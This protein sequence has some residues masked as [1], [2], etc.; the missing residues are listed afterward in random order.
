VLLEIHDPAIAKAAGVPC[1]HLSAQGCSVHPNWPKV[2][3]TW[4]CVWRLMPGLPEQWRP[5]LSGILLYQVRNEVPGYHDTAL[6]L[7][8]AHGLKHL[9]NEELL[10]FVTLA[11]RN[12]QPVYLGVHKLKDGKGASAADNKAVFINLSLEPAIARND[13]AGFVEILKRTIE[14]KLAQ[15]GTAA[16]NGS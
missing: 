11:V 9:E 13:R 5:D 6:M 15:P 12:R 3:Q 16:M 10:E 4:F 7:S 8:L 2:C 1:R 14:A